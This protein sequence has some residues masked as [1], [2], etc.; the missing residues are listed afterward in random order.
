M[1]LK[2]CRFVAFLFVALVLAAGLARLFV[3]PAKMA[4]PAAA[5][6]TAQHIYSGWELLGIAIAGALLS[7]G[8]LAWQLRPRS[9]RALFLSSAR[10]PR[11]LSARQGRPRAC[12]LTMAAFLAIV[13]DKAIVWLL[14]HPANQATGNWTFLPDNWL[15]LR[16]QWEYA[17]AVGA[18][19]DLLAFLALVMS[20][21]VTERPLRVRDSDE[22]S[23]GR[24]APLR[25][26]AVR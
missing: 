19:L 1:M 12:A 22:A 6:L 20:V 4:L 25:F 23:G 13:A 21:L 9:G 18:L 11:S 15:A 24:G 10:R 17:H 3:M 26:M 8:T 2:T 16:A 5:Y 14:A 7:L